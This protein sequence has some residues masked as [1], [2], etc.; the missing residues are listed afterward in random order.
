MALTPSLLTF[1]GHNNQGLQVANNF[2]HISNH[3]Y[4]SQP[5]MFSQD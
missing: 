1:S 4:I 5:G 3:L 2:G